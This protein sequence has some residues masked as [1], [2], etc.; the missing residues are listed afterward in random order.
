MSTAAFRA[1]SFGVILV[2]V[3]ISLIFFN[4]GFA[5]SSIASLGES[6]RATS[7]S[8]SLPLMYSSVYEVPN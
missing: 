8:M 3:N 4:D 6:K 1:P 5:A 2:S 7:L